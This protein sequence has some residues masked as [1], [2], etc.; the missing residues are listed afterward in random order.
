MK[1]NTVNYNLAGDLQQLLIRTGIGFNLT[2]NNNNILLGYGYFHSQNYIANTDTKIG[3]NE[4]RI[5]QQFLTRQ[6][7]GRVTIQH[8]YRIEERFVEADFAMR[9]R[10]FLGVNIALNN[11][12]L[13]NNTVYASAYNELFVNAQNTVFDRIR[14]YGAMGYVVNANFR[15][16]LGYMSQILQNAHGEQLQVMLINKL[17]LRN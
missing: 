9:F 6:V 1:F 8:R 11:K 4:S 17:P 5:F 13:I 7:F 10:Y 2:E 15:F 14:L 16:E 12:T 3:T